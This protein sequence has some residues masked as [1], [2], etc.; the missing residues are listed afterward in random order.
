MVRLWMQWIRT[1]PTSHHIHNRNCVLSKRLWRSC[2]S[3]TF[4]MPYKPKLSAL[5]SLSLS[6]SLNAHR[7]MNC[8]A[9]K[10]AP[11]V[12]LILWPLL[13]FMS[14]LFNFNTIKCSPAHPDLLLHSVR[15]PFSSVH[16]HILRF[17]H[18]NF[19]KTQR[20]QFVSLFPC[21]IPFFTPHSA[22]HLISCFYFVL[23]R[24][25]CF[26]IMR[27]YYDFSSFLR[28]V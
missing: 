7:C 20:T 21:I 2:Q 27:Y 19:Y 13:L 15:P 16:L 12:V 1:L 14:A 11:L 8:I 18:C 3:Y 10:A 6:H 9:V 24:F 26:F 17:G 22:I 25:W 5:V 28:F 4:S 23:F